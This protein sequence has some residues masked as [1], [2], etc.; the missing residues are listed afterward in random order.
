[1]PHLEHKG[2][3]VALPSVQ[4]YDLFHFPILM[5]RTDGVATI[6]FFQLD[7]GDNVLR[8]HNQGLSEP[9]HH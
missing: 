1:M 2:K 5:A 7:R 3:D 4:R 8:L 6:S 9:R